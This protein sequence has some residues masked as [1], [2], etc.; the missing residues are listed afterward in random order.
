MNK[1]M[2]KLFFFFF[3][4]KGL[5]WQNCERRHPDFFSLH[6]VASCTIVLIVTDVTLN[7]MPQHSEMMR[8]KDAKD[9]A[10]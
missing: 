8:S 2:V 6:G 1:K 10:T 9:Q 3:L 7:Y 4:A 5:P